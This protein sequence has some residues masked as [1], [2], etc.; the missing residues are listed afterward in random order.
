MDK[1]VPVKKIISL[2]GQQIGA[3]WIA[4]EALKK[5]QKEKFDIILLPTSATE[6]VAQKYVNYLMA[7]DKFYDNLVI[8]ILEDTSSSVLKNALSEYVDDSVIAYNSAGGMGYQQATAVF[9]L[10]L[11]KTIFLY[12]SAANVIFFT[13][14]DFSP[15]I[16]RKEYVKI[17]P[18][19]LLRFHNINPINAVGSTSE[20]QCL[21]L[22]IEKKYAEYGD[23]IF[24][25]N[26]VVNDFLFNFTVYL[27]NTFYF[28]KFFVNNHENDDKDFRRN[29]IREIECYASKEKTNDIFQKKV[30]VFSNSRLWRDIIE[31]S[32]SN[33]VIFVWL[34]R[35]HLNNFES[36][37]GFV[38]DKINAIAGEGIEVFGDKTGKISSRSYN[39][40]ES[41]CNKNL[42]MPL[43]TDSRFAFEVITSHLPL[44]KVFLFVDKNFGRKKELEK[45]LISYFEDAEYR[46]SSIDVVSVDFFGI[47][48]LKFNKPFDPA[49]YEAEINC[50][51]GHK[52]FTLMMALYGIKND[53]PV[54]SYTKGFIKQI[55]TGAMRKAFSQNS[56][57]KS[58]GDIALFFKNNRR[59]KMD[60]MP[61]VTYKFKTAR[62]VYLK[63][64][65]NSDLETLD[66]I[67]H[68]TRH[69]PWFEKFTAY[70]FSLVSDVVD[71]AINFK[72]MWSKDID[73]MLSAKYENEDFM[74]EF[75]VVCYHRR[76]TQSPFFIIVSCKHMDLGL[77]NI[78]K[79]SRDINAAKQTL[80]DRFAIPVLAV[81]SYLGEP[82]EDNGILVI[83]IKT[84][85]STNA[86]Q[87]CLR[88]LIDSKSTT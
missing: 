56:N 84:L 13:V 26:L 29:F 69:G 59:V 24:F 22:K 2:V 34:D 12:P 27:N 50:T 71:V 15:T 6:I 85:I 68:P 14:A 17:N 75:D 31:S 23:N 36:A 80:F 40:G 74:K 9:S 44:N 57:T 45:N 54:F 21:L 10:N 77:V 60:S 4:V 20:Y 1:L 52:L 66:A 35:H 55:P 82:F 28:V 42:L 61:D 39:L 49:L 63:W 62:K 37:D 3:T 7:G 58:S 79:E 83:G 53:I 41:T 46:P 25:K 76:S 65:F 48:I 87:T 5:I 47:N 64:A 16:I 73:D 86:L 11:N 18:S 67:P 81:S 19:G 51:P 38:F 8:D 72:F 32:W 43:G 33:K 88:E 30:I 70:C 78:E